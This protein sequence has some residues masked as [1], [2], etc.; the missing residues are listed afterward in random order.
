MKN[1]IIELWNYILAGFLALWGLIFMSAPGLVYKGSFAGIGI[2]SKPSMYAMITFNDPIVA[3][4]AVFQ[5]FMIIISALLLAFC[6]VRIAKG[7]GVKFEAI[8]KLFG[9]KVFNR[10]D[11]VT[12]AAFAYTL[13]SFLV[14]VLLSAYAGKS[15]KVGGVSKVSIGFGPVWLFI[16]GAVV[17]AGLVFKDCIVKYLC[18]EKVSELQKTEV[19]DGEESDPQAGEQEEDTGE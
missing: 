18:K 7:F 6:A 16:W 2:L 10:F 14:M 19:S 1:K 11:I 8:D 15:G 9:V 3:A 5:I 4:A 13:F 17:C 12:L